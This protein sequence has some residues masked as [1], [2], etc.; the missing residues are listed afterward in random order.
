MCVYIYENSFKPWVHTQYT[1][2]KK[3]MLHVTEILPRPHPKTR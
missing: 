2:E 1:K 3:P